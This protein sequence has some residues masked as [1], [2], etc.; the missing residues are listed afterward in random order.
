MTRSGR[1]RLTRS[2]HLLKAVLLTALMA[3]LTSPAPWPRVALPHA[4]ATLQISMTPGLYPDFD[5]DISDYVVP[6]D[7]SAF[8][9]VSVDAPRNTKVSVDGQPFR[10]LAFTTSVNVTPGQSFTLVVN[11]P[12]K[13]ATYHV[14][15]L[16][17]DFP[18]WT[19]ERYG[20]PPAEF[21]VVAP[22][23]STLPGSPRR[24][25]VIL[26]DN[27]GVPIWWHSSLGSL[28]DAKV[29]PNG[30]IAW[31]SSP[32]AEEYLLDGTLVRTLTTPTPGGIDLHELQLLSN[33]NYIYIVY[34]PRG[35]VDLSPYGGSATATVFDSVIEEVTPAGKI[36]WSWSTMDHIP[37]SETGPQWRQRYFVDPTIANPPRPADPYHMNSIEEDGDGFVVSLRHLDTVLRIDKATGNITWKL[38][39]ATRPESLTFVGDPYGNF[40][41]Q[42][43]ARI[44][45]D[46]TLTVHDNGTFQDRP[47]RA[48]R[49]SID[50]IAKTATLIEQVTDPDAPSSACCGSAR[51][52][53][54]GDWVME[55]GFNPVVTALTPAGER[56][57]R[58][59]FPGSYFSYRAAPVLYGTLSREALR[60]GMDAQYPRTLAGQFPRGIRGVS[61][62]RGIPTL[63]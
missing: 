12:G 55:W 18:S 6:Y 15:C 9:Q 29:L 1:S 41:G 44:L 34:E 36:V 10:K 16:P 23:Q 50:P 40:G 47:P 62:S 38:S 57:F 30:H 31:I 32:K 33:G 46:G 45:P 8:V 48:V 11:S 61:R 59:T 24:H 19:T 42:H 22:N 63:R 58:I 52:L 20:T 14:R 7:P 39:G 2:H 60:A 53:P 28:F 51:K 13:S 25:Y 3:L 4:S 56:L 35:P 49:Y 43:D 27:Y 17:T 21:Y 54:D 37:V 26:V 5:P